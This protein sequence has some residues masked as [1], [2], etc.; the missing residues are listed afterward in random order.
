[1]K[2]TNKIIPI[3]TGLLFNKPFEQL[4]F[5]FKKQQG[6]Y[7]NRYGWDKSNFSMYDLESWGRSKEL[8]FKLYYL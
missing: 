1:M 8:V 3:K 2:I 5:L 6:I 7:L 4:G